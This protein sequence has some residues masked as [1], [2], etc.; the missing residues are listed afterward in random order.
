[1]FGGLANWTDS[2]DGILKCRFDYLL[3]RWDL[4]QAQY[5][6][7]L[8]VT[9]YSFDYNHLDLFCCELN[10]LICYLSAILCDDYPIPLKLLVDSVNDDSYL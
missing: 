3:H 4:Y 6:E 5:I 2:N 7:V 8:V 1:M 10:A 9:F